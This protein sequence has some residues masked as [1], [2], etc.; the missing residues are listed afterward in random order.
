MIYNPFVRNL[1]FFISFLLIISNSDKNYV[2]S[3]TISYIEITKLILNGQLYDAINPYWSPLYS[4]I[5][6]FFSLVLFQ[7]QDTFLIIQIAS[8][9]IYIFQTFCF[10]FFL[11]NF[12]KYNS[13]NTNNYLSNK[14]L[15]IFG[16]LIYLICCHFCI[17]SSFKTPDS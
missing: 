15:Y 4:L 14:Q 13:L 1:F 6:S 9:F 17:P 7:I 10:H 8:I 16:F 11:I 2:F 12:L 5:L 3:D